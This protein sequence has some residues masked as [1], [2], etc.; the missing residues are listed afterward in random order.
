MAALIICVCFEKYYTFKIV[1][2]KQTINN[3][4]SAKNILVYPCNLKS[5]YCMNEKSMSC[6]IHFFKIS[7]CSIV[8][9]NRTIKKNCR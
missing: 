3:I 9:K 7:V 2:N 8:Y 6:A 5:F 4:K 1:K